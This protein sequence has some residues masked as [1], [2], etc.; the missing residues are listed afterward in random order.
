MK[1]IAS[2]ASKTHRLDGSLKLRAIM[3]V[4]FVREGHLACQIML[5]IR[6][7]GESIFVFPQMLRYVTS[8]QKEAFLAPRKILLQDKI[9]FGDGGKMI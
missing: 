9:M 7:I 3:A 5:A 4:H 2:Q 8:L 6:Q 1:F